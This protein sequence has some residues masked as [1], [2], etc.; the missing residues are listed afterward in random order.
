MG[1]Q[2]N[3]RV[4]GLEKECSSLAWLAQHAIGFQANPKVVYS[5][6]MSGN[7]NGLAF[8][9]PTLPPSGDFETVQK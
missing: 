4:H 1:V 5:H 7:I 3:L 8:E 9:D 6:C 2:G